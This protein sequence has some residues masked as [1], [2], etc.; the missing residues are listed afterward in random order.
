MGIGDCVLIYEGNYR[1]GE[2]NGI[3]K[4]YFIKFKIEILKRNSFINGKKVE[5]KFAELVENLIK[6]KKENKPKF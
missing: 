4:E 1:N 5:I 2:R 3:G 6:L